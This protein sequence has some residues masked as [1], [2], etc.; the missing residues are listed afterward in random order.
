[1][2]RKG[3]TVELDHHAPEYARNGHAILRELRAEC[4]VAYSE[5][6]GG[7]WVVSDYEHIVEVV[8]DDATYSSAYEADTPFDGITI[9]SGGPRI[10]NVPIEMDPPEFFAYRRMLNPWFSPAAVARL[11]P[12]LRQVVDAVIDKVIESGRI[13]LVLDLANPVPAIMTLHLLGLPLEDWELYAGAAHEANSTLPDTPERERA[14]V[15]LYDVMNKLAEAIRERRASPRD[16]LISFLVQV[17]VEGKTLSDDEA[18]E[19]V[20]LVLQG[21][22]DTTTSLMANAL[23]YLHHD[24]DARKRLIEEP[25]LRKFACEE[26][27]RVVTPVQTLA[28]TVTRDTELGDCQLRQGDRVLIAWASANRD[29][30]MFPQPDTILLDRAPNRHLSFG[31]GIHRCIGSNIARAQFLAVLDAVLLRM[32]DYN[33]IEEEVRRYHSIGM[34]HGVITIPATFTPGQRTGQSIFD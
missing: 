26:F 34:V 15:D 21:G 25:E 23:L 29:E 16:D 1:V 24:R 13:D 31:I 12:K 11:E 8:K 33:V 30:R 22:V 2:E 7:M 6:Y 9:P 5:S 17:E 20:S 32:P 4:P 3:P 27:L 28:R 18:L 19:I 14:L 10:R